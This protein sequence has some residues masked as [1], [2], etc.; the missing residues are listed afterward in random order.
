MK[1]AVMDHSYFRIP[2]PVVPHST[3]EAAAYSDKGA[4]LSIVMFL[5]APV[6]LVGM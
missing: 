3:I 6:G 1:G 5:V 2:V 4:L